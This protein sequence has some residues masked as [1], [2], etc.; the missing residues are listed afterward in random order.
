[1]GLSYSIFF[2]TTRS[3]DKRTARL[4]VDKRLYQAGRTLISSLIESKKRIN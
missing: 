3:A 1:M 4:I 2:N